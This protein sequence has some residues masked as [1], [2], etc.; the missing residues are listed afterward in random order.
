RALEELRPDY[1]GPIEF[2]AAGANTGGYHDADAPHVRS[3]GVL[4]MTTREEGK[5]WNWERLEEFY[6]R[7][8]DAGLNPQIL[9]G[10]QAA[11]RFPGYSAKDGEFRALYIPKYA[12][13]DVTRYR[14]GLLEF[15]RERLGSQRVVCDATQIELMPGGVRFHAR[16][17]ARTARLSAGLLVFWTPRLSPWVLAQAHKAEAAPL[18]PKGARLW[19][20][21]LLNSRDAPDPS[22]IGMHEDMAV[23]ADA[24]G[25]PRDTGLLAVLRAGPLVKPEMLNHPKGGLSW[26]SGESFSALGGLCQGLL[27]WDRFSVRSM[28]PRA[29]FEWENPSPFQIPSPGT[30]VCIVPGADGPLLEVVRRARAACD[31]FAEVPA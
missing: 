18:V 30:Q 3:R 22:A 19:E 7:A 2:W 25:V 29:I 26:G 16:G 10:I 23:W 17:E 27:K 21:W 31:Q 1:P 11:K 5:F 28:R 15:I 20:E 9:E 24:E 12:D 13:V 4:W 6:V 8:S 14:H